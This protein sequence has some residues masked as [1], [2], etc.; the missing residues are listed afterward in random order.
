MDQVESHAVSI[1]VNAPAE[2]AFA[3][4]ADPGHL[5]LWAFERAV[6]DDS[7]LVRGHSRFDG[8]PVF[9]RIDADQVRLMIDFQV[10]GQADQLV[11]RIMARIIPGGRLGWLDRHCAMA[12]LAWRSAAMDDFRWRKLVASHEL[13]IC[14]LKEL[15]E[16]HK[17]S[18]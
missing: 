5:G 12:L 16:R 9:A 17:K 8:S 18:F 6:V 15:I 10:G 11:P 13:E 14:L 4:V 3:F 7:G 2:E 1:L